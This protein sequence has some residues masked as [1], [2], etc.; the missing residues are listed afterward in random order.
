MPKNCSLCIMCNSSTPEST[1][2]NRMIW[3]TF[4]SSC[5]GICHM[6]IY[7]LFNV[8]I[9][10]SAVTIRIPTE[11]SIANWFKFRIEYGFA[12]QELKNIP[13]QENAGVKVTM[14]ER[15]FSHVCTTKLQ[16]RL[17]QSFSDNFPDKTYI[18]ACRISKN[19]SYS[20]C[21]HL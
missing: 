10:L 8:K 14:S 16:T 7:L 4:H 2:V 13:Q 15:L 11:F 9:F 18:L 17:H 6:I 3:C 5:V 1:K 20:Y 19:I 21:E 12:C